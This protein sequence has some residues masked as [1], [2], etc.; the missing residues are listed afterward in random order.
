MQN[1]D[2][3]FGERLFFVLYLSHHP[4]TIKHAIPGRGGC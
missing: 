4:E 3:Y 1:R 2:V